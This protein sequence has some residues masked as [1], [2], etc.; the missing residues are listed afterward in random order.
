[1]HT[2]L[3][4]SLGR[5][6]P[7]G[8]KRAIRRA[9]TLTSRRRPNDGRQALSRPRPSEP[10]TEPLLAQFAGHIDRAIEQDDAAAISKLT[11]EFHHL[12]ELIEYRLSPG[13]EKLDAPLELRSG[14]Q[15]KQFMIDLLPYIQDHLAT[16]SRGRTFSVL[17]VG[18]G[19]GHGTALLSSL[20]ASSHLGYRLNVTAVDIVDHYHAYIRLIGR[21]MCHKVDDIFRMTERFDIVIASHVIEHVH[22][23]VGFCHRLRELAKQ[24]VFIVAPFNEP[25][26]RLT[27]GHR[28]V[29]N[30][31][32]IA[33]LKPTRTII[34]NSVSW[35]AFYD[36]PYEMVIAE[37]PGLSTSS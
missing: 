26:D 9:G 25:R 23:P 5:W 7:P 4:R 24:V 31:T 11:D 16:Y 8:A 37:L 30:D 20:Y 13:R 28:N 36:P 2:D 1:M 19:T 10:L 27:K 29:I 21:H 12:Q 6:L 35:G 33:E 22:D 3:A 15:S 34:M 32:T 18:P 14:A 17:D